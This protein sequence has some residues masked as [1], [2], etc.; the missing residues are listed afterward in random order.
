MTRDFGQQ[1]PGST[2][3][4]TASLSFTAAT[5]QIAGAN[6]TF[7]NFAVGDRAQVEGTVTNDG[8]FQVTGIDATNHAYLVVAPP[9]KD[10]G[11][12]SA[13]LRKIT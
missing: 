13:T 2:N 8:G 3:Q 7:A 9:P 5:G 1:D 11:A 6:G 10:Q 12:I 4:V